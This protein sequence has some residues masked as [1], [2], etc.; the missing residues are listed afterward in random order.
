MRPFDLVIEFYFV[1]IK[2]MS[3]NH[4]D[5]LIEQYQVVAGPY[6]NKQDADIQHVHH[7]NKLEYKGQSLVTVSGTGQFSDLYEY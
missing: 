6:F 7:L 2:S 4:E 3:Y 5:E 1:A